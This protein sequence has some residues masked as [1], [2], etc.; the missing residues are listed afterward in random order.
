MK[1]KPFVSWLTLSF[2]LITALRILGAGKAAAAL[3]NGSTPLAWIVLRSAFGPYTW[4]ITCKYCGMVS[5]SERPIKKTV[6]A[7][8]SFQACGPGLPL[9]FAV[10][11]AF[12]SSS[13]DFVS[14]A[15]LRRNVI[16]PYHIMLLK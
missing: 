7:Y 15:S 12:T 3:T 1:R 10:W 13:A 4:S 11:I 5:A 16:R 14:S 9:T 8:R 2:T 6:G